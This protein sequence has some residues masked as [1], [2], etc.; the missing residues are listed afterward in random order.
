M[1]S[2]L[3]ADDNPNKMLMIQGMLFKAGWT[4]EVLTAATS[5]DAKKLIDAHDIGF[6]LI[7]FYIPKENGPAIIAHLKNKN[8]SARIALV[9]SSDA[10]A[11]QLAA[12]EAGAETCI[13]TTHEA[14]EVESA[15]KN[16]L[17]EWME[18]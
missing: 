15:F 9:S 1:Q 12:R 18:N 10:Y 17:A 4:G 2:I 14:D 8:P 11:N 16:L 13:C 5:D 6:G 7:D 3:I